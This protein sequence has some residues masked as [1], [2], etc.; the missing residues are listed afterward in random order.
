MHI[1]TRTFIGTIIA[2]AA[3]LSVQGQDPALLSQGQLIWDNAPAADWDTGYP[4]GNGRLGAVALGNWPR[5][6]FVLN[7][8]TIWRKSPRG[9]TPDDSF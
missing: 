9:L 1:A 8:E 6:R 3:M 7:E 4:V 2:L 5:E